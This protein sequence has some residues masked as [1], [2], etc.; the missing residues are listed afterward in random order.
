MTAPARLLDYRLQR[1]DSH[2]GDQSSHV[3]A[4]REYACLV[5]VPGRRRGT[6][7]PRQEAERREQ[8]PHLVCLQRTQACME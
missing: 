3:A 8:V 7:L 1:L 4:R 6:Q 2:G 5:G